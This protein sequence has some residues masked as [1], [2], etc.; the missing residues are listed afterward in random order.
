MSGASSRLFLDNAW[1][2]SSG[3][4]APGVLASGKAT[5]FLQR[6]RAF[7]GGAR[8][9]IFAGSE[10]GGA[11]NVSYA[12]ART[13]GVGSP[14]FWPV[15][16]IN[17]EG[18]ICETEK[19]PMLVMDG[20]SFAKIRAGSAIASAL[21][22]TVVYNSGNRTEGAL[23]DLDEMEL[24][25]TG[26]DMPG[27]WFGNTIATAFLNYVELYSYSKQLVVANRSIVAPTFDRFVGP[28]ASG[29]ANI[30]PAIVDVHVKNSQLV[31]DIVALQGSTINLFL[32]EGTTLTGSV[33]TDS[34]N[35]TVNVRI[36]SGARWIMTDRSE[37]GE[38]QNDDASHK[39]IVTNGHNLVA[40]VSQVI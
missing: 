14:C 3:P 9:S 11:L 21:A 13:T 26:R 39:N 22:A 8:S 35:A 25:V 4:G 12:T 33:Y 40:T 31:G 30:Q 32:G 17:A 20:A 16:Q 38:L 37:V 2:Y 29:G 18:V 23:L 28:E 10:P 34:S 36:Q 5:A 1:L 19:S 6:I 7:S 15:G 27:L 24:T